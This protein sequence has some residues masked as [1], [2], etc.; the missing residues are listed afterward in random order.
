MKSATDS[1]WGSKGV[2]PNG[3]QQGGLG[4]CWFLAA[5]AAVAETPSRIE[6]MFRNTQ[7]SA[8]GIYQTKFYIGGKATWVTT[9]D[10]IPAR[11]WGS[12]FAPFNVRKSPAGAWWMPILEKAYA[13]VNVNYAQLNGGTQTESFAGLT[14]MPIQSFSTSRDLTTA[15]KIWDAISNADL[16]NWVMSSSCMRS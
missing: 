3:V 15:D 5:A 13:K 7:L 14:G 1:L 9:D 4:D 11:P 16:K 12:G 2:L 8:D 10:K 6:K